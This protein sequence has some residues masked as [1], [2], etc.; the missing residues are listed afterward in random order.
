QQRATAVGLQQRGAIRLGEIADLV[1][2]TVPTDFDTTCLLDDC[3]LHRVIVGGN[4]VFEA[5]NVVHACAGK[6]ITGPL[7]RNS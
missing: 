3:D 6:L 4:V 7:G 5:G 2:L 1:M